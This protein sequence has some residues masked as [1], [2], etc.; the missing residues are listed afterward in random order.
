M[1]TT[2]RL[3]M[4][5]ALVVGLLLPL[6]A[7]ADELMDERVDEQLEEEPAVAPPVGGEVARSVFT[8]G[9]TEREP[10]DELQNID[11]GA[12]DLAY[13]TELKGLDGQTIIHRWEY[14]GQVM[15]EVAFDVAGPRWRVHSTKQLDPSLTGA[16]TVKVLDTHGNILTQD[17][18]EYRPAIAS[19]EEPA[20]APP[21]APAE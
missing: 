18:I 12:Q 10:L 19:I 11:E 7:S 5:S 15:G 1:G 21:A 6:S 3:L 20:A 17:Q 8:S 2:I 13:F 14:D 16:W 4:R 9:V